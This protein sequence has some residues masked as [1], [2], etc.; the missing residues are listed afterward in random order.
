MCFK[1]KV[2]NH[3]LQFPDSNALRF[4]RCF[5]MHYGNYLT[6]HMSTYLPTSLQGPTSHS[7]ASV[8]HTT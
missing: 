7:A 8:G 3:A 2:L 5:V 4:I 6:F 1:A